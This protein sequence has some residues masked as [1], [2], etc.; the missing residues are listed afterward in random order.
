MTTVYV[1]TSGSYEDY[2]IEGI[3]STKQQAED[4]IS[5]LNK[6]YDDHL[7]IDYPNL[8]PDDIY[9][10]EEHTLDSLSTILKEEDITY[11][12][13]CKV[14][15][16]TEYYGGV[17]YGRKQGTYSVKRK[18]IAK[19][20]IPK[21]QP[22]KERYGCFYCSSLI[23]EQDTIDK[24]YKYYQDYLNFSGKCNT[25]VWEKVEND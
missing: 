2:K 20:D 19:Q 21:L 24:G 25:G 8:I 11:Y 1:V 6:I 18:V 15:T 4:F 7:L 3:F 23:S 12:W 5:P 22:Y 16:H 13:E 14:T 9:S 17:Y 10:I